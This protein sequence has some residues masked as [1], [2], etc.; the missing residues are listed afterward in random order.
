MTKSGNARKFVHAGGTGSNTLK[1]IT[2]AALMLA[3]AFFARPYFVGGLDIEINQASAAAENSAAAPPEPPA[4]PVVG[5]VVIKA[6][7]AIGREYIGR[8]E[9]IQSVL[10][11]PRISGQIETVHFKEGSIVKEGDLL[12]TLDSAQ[13]QATVALHRADLAKAQANM[14]KA[15]KYND[16][17]KAADKRSVSASD[18]D[19]AA[20]EALQNKAA[21][22]QAKAALKLAQIDLDFTK[23]RA[24]ITGRI[25]RAEATKGNYVTPGGGLAT[26]VQTDPIRVS[27]SI[28]DRDYMAQIEAF[29]SS[30]GP[31]YDI[32]LLLSDGTSYKSGGERDFE[33]NT[34]DTMTGTITLRRRFENDGGTLIPGSMV[35]VSAK[36]VK[37]HIAPV[38]PQEA[39]MSDARGD[40]VYV[41][42]DGNIADRRDVE[43]GAEIGATREVISGLEAGEKVVLSGLHNVQPG[44][45]VRPSYPSSDASAASPADL[46]RES[47]YDLRAVVSA[48]DGGSGEGTD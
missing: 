46:A 29:Q 34:I 17:L 7:L 23:I 12:F 44:S 10:L 22:D 9:P 39:L 37:N 15:V 43:L 3:V 40:F 16:R 8:V 28:P 6:D 33:D 48:D 4:P 25:G 5:H 45:P 36:P 35:R 14:A 47:G 19:I 20:S 13:H 42:G 38:L 41:I 32:S 21:V 31:V 27:Y 26:I 30:E 2:A 24:P 11:K 1:S 18:L